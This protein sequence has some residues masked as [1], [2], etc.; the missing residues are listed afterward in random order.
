M[1]LNAFEQELKPERRFPLRIL[2]R[3]NTIAGR[4]RQ[5]VIESGIGGP[6]GRQ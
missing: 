4:P 2:G 3:D 1:P 6:L 5:D